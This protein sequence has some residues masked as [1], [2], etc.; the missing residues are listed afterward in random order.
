MK[1]EELLE[2]VGTESLFETGLLMAGVVDPPAL[3]RQ[4]SR[5]VKAGR[6]VKL[7]RGLY[8]VASPHR[9]ASPDPFIVSNRL[10][11]PSYVSLESA[12]H[13]HEIIP[14]VPF[15][16]T[17]V[18]TGRGGVH[19]T[20]LGRFV[21]HHIRTDRLWGSIEI[22]IAAGQRGAWIARPE[23]ALIDL[24]YLNPASDDPA[25]L[26]QLRLQNTERFDRGV[27]AEM[28]ARF[29]SPRVSRAMETVVSLMREDTEGWVVV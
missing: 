10:V 18:T 15:A 11:R 24:L 20:P 5:W 27:L 23:K 14:D 22:R 16:V 6:L 12:L 19:D 21:F 3:Q 29:G 28:A 2:V 26:R 7:R 4:L 13:Y 8:S 25:Y 17:A 9:I 1:Y